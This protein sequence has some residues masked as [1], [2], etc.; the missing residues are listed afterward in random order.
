M[1]SV[2]LDKCPEASQML[3][4]V[5]IQA[6]KQQPAQ[7]DKLQFNTDDYWWVLWYNINIPLPLP[8]VVWHL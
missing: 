8:H 3:K 2:F 5:K 1:I 4:L 7:T 6:S